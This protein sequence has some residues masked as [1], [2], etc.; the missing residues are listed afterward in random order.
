MAFQQVFQKDNEALD[1]WLE[2]G[3]DGLVEWQLSLGFKLFPRV[4]ITPNS[5]QEG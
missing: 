4:L 2:N 3:G 1:V 5:Y